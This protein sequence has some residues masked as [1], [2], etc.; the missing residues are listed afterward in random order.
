[1]EKEEQEKKI[2]GTMIIDVVKTIKDIKDVPWDDHLSEDARRLL[3]ENFL[4]SSWY[5]YQPVLECVWAV[6]RLLGNSD[7]DAAR[8]WGKANGR[9]VF[10]TVYKN[11]AAE[12]DTET[13]LIKLDLLARSAFV[14]GLESKVERLAERHYRVYIYDEGP[15]GEVTCY[16]VQGWIEAIIEMTGGHNGRVEILDK[17]WNGAECTVIDVKWG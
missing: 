1:M 11:I 9:K 14:K 12:Q 3:T 17:H 15:G 8:Q 13:A 2:K 5:P 10:E 7:P 6:Y 16:L 4:P